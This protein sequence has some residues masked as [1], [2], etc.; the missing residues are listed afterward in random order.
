[1]KQ[2]RVFREVPLLFRFINLLSFFGNYFSITLENKL[3]DD[4][5]MFLQLFILF[6]CLAKTS[7]YRA[8]V[9]SNYANC[10]EQKNIFTLQESNPQG[11]FW[12][13]RHRRHFVLHMA[14]VKSRENDL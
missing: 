2:Y 3:C 1:M 8:T 10:L 6:F 13:Y 14:A 12:V 9:T 7:S 5:F 4:L 11:I